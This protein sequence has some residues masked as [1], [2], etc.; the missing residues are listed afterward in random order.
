MVN[1]CHYLQDK[2]LSAKSNIAHR[3]LTL[4]MYIIYEFLKLDVT[5]VRKRFEILKIRTELYIVSISL[6]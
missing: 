6:N 4:H 5:Q 3:L 2:V 1:V